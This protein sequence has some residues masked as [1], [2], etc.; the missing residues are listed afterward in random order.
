M[1]RTIKTILGALTITSILA[2]SVSAEP[3][4]TKPADWRENYAY[5]M[6]VQAYLLY[7][8]RVLLSDIRW[9]W[10]AKPTTDPSETS[11][12]L[13]YFHHS[14]NLITPEWRSGG[15]PNNDTLYSFAW[16]DISKEPIILSHGDMADDRYFA[17][18][19][20]TMTSDN[21]AYVSGLSTGHKAG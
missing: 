15:S 14:R 19:M 6:G 4:E 10:V 16:L 5:T 20:G 12:P 2:G 11:A 21:F 3:E 8:P 17:F 1:K 18:E 7:F 9:Q 13:N